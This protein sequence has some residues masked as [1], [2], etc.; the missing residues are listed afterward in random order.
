MTAA[1]TQPDPIGSDFDWSRWVRLDQAA[2][3]LDTSAGNLRRQC[4]D[5]LLG[6]ALAMKAKAPGESQTTWWIHRRHDLR[7]APGSVGERHREPT[8]EE[9]GVPAHRADEARRR[10]DCVTELRRWRS[11]RDDLQRDW[12]PLLMDELQATHPDLKISRTSLLRWDQTYRA[13]AD[14]ALLV[15]RRGGAADKSA[16]PRCWAYFEQLFLDDRQ[17]K[18]AECWRKTQLF[19]KG[20]GL[21]WCSQRSCYAQ[22]DERIPPSKQAYHRDRAYY[23]SAFLPT[24]AQDVDRFAAGRCWVADHTTLDFFVRVGTKVFRATLTTFQDFKTRRIVG[25][26]AAEKPSSDTILLALKEGLEDPV[27]MGG[28]TEVCF[29]NGKDF[30]SRVFDGRT[31]SERRRER[32]GDFCVE[33]GGFRGILGELNIRPHFSIA[34]APNGKARMERWY[35]TL[36]DQFCRSFVTYTGKDHKAKPDGL[37]RRLA[38]PSQCPS[39][40]EVNR[41]LADYIR[42]YNANASHAIDDL[43]V[44]GVR[45]SPDEAMHR[46]CTEQRVF[47]PGALDLLLLHHEREVTVGKQGVSIRIAGELYHYGLMQPELLPYQGT[48]KKVRPAYDPRDLRTI[49]VFD[50]ATN[51]LICVARS[52]EIGGEEG[53]VGRQQLAAFKR[54]ARGHQKLLKKAGLDALVPSLSSLELMA[55]SDGIPPTAEPMTETLAPV[56]TRF[57]GQERDVRRHELKAAAGAETD[58]HPDQKRPTKRGRPDLLERIDPGPAPGEPPAELAPEDEHAPVASSEEQPAAANDGVSPIGRIGGVD[59]DASPDLTPDFDETDDTEASDDS[60][61]RDLLAELYE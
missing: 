29:D 33:E 25:W 48:R 53:P 30:D 41:R 32:S 31:K 56:A 21:R 45:L 46:W 58:T 28:P 54:K 38:D 37:A 8:L 55:E 20:E 51:R 49:K 27:N 39:W 59:P 24:L 22:L 10:R 15:D 14:L 3:L 50:A 61:P 7:L 42:A 6:Q 4:A 16:D 17:P 11:S 36:H 44:D 12:L 40:Q 5:K 18:A 1:L 52:N 19:A 23:N 9:T 57:D 2:L 13:P 43:T 35:G 47:N 26:C 60:S 34:Y